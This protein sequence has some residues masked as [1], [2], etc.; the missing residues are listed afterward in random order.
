MTTTEQSAAWKAHRRLLAVS[1]PVAAVLLVVG[2][3]IMPKGLDNQSSSL[4]ETTKQVMIAGRHVDRFDA[5]SLL[6]IFGL[7]AAG[8]SFSGIATLTRH[9][10]AVL[11]TIAALVGAVALTCGVVANST[12]NLALA[13]AAAV[14]PAVN[15]AGR[16]WVHVDA[17]PL[18]NTL[19]VVYFFGWMVAIVLAAIALWRSRAI[20]RWAAVVFAVAYLVS[21][22]TGP[23]A[24]GVV[25]SLPFVAIMAYL[26][27]R[28]WQTTAPTSS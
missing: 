19:S 20:P 5:A 3:G 7:A 13:E 4:A 1:L 18:A 28:V 11:A 10:G 21:N 23:G 15:V 6:I 8:V 25:V 22:F 27:F 26:A 2:E 24:T 9:R 12:D 16:I 14:H 17:S